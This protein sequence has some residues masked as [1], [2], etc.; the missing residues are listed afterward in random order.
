MHHLKAALCNATLGGLFIMPLPTH[1]S[2]TAPA[3][4]SFPSSWGP[5]HCWAGCR[6][7]ILAEAGR[8]ETSAPEGAEI[9]VRAMVSSCSCCTQ[10]SA[11]HSVG[12]VTA[13]YVVLL[14]HSPLLQ[15]AH[16]EDGSSELHSVLRKAEMEGE[17]SVFEALH[18]NA[19]TRVML[20]SPGEG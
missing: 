17:Q 8:V 1:P 16:P 18:S 19:V 5:W 14:L 7:W 4:L 11:L 12:F 15:K 3:S 10:P 6:Q 2:C 13:G 9:W 20:K